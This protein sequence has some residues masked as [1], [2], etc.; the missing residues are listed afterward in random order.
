MVFRRQVVRHDR[1]MNRMFR[2]HLSDRP[3]YGEIAVKDPLNHQNQ[4]KPG[5]AGTRWS[6]LTGAVKSGV[7]A[8]RVKQPIEATSAAFAERADEA[9]DCE[10]WD[11]LS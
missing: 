11:G 5:E 1:Q 4:A 7:A 2:S 8:S 6:G 9:E 3:A 10:R